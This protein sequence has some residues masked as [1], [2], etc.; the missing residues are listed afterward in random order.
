MTDEPPAPQGES[1]VARWHRLS[2][3]PDNVTDDG[4]I[5][6]ADAGR[7]LQMEK[8]QLRATIT[9]IRESDAPAA[10][11]ADARLAASY[12]LAGDVET[13]RRYVARARERAARDDAA[14]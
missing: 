12:L 2:G 14:S 3:Q 4:E 9:Q 6:S 7:R 5:V 11:K 1:D 13:A 10:A 8:A